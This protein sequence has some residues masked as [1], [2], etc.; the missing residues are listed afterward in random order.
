ML[1]VPVESAVKTYQVSGAEP[2]I[3]LRSQ[4]TPNRKNSRRTAKF[5]GFLV[6]ETA[7]AAAHRNLIAIYRKC[8][9]ARS[10]NTVAVTIVDIKL[11]ATYIIGHTN[12]LRV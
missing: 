10:V 7:A 9:V 5:G 11:Q 1:Y 3:A 4:E 12:G 8:V 6:V 2:L